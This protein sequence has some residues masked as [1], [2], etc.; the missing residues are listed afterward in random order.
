VRRCRY[1]VQGNLENCLAAIHD[2]ITLSVR[3]FFPSFAIRLFLLSGV[4]ALVATPPKISRSPSTS[5]WIAKVYCNIH[6]SWGREYIRM[7]C[8]VQVYNCDL[9]EQSEHYVGFLDHFWEKKYT[10]ESMIKLKTTYSTQ[11]T[12]IAIF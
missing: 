4:M 2:K 3:V 11:F 1:V 8:D 10:F 6:S 9:A 5:D 7:Y 12:I